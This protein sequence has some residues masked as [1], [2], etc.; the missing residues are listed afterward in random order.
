MY[1]KLNNLKGVNDDKFCQ[2]NDEDQGEDTEFLGMLNL[3][4]RRKK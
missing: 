1:R 4:K 2:P 3:I